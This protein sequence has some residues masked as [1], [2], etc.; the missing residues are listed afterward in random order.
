MYESPFRVVDLLENIEAVFGDA[1]CVVARE[2][3]KIHE[4]FIRGPASAVRKN[5]AARPEI[6]GEIV[7][8]AAPQLNIPQGE[9]K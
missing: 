5:L 7:V 4:E 6:L 9:I 8:I 2:I 1:P 3:T